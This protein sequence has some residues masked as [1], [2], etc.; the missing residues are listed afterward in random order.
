MNGFAVNGCAKE[1][2]KV[3]VEM[4]NK[5]VKPNDITMIGVLSACSHG[6]LVNEGKKW[7]KAMEEF[8]LSTKTELYDCMVD[9]LGKAGCVEE[10]EILINSMPYE[11]NQIILG[12]LLFT[13]GCAWI[14]L[15]NP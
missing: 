14:A 7:F 1:A 10:A 4:Q 15:P 2:L 13:C 3:F 12:S 5:G 11:A 6:G 9:I 8:G